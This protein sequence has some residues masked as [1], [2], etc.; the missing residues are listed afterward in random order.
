[1]VAM[2]FFWATLSGKAS[3]KE[4]SPRNGCWA[5]EETAAGAEALV[6][7]PKKAQVPTMAVEVAIVATTLGTLQEFTLGGAAASCGA[8]PT[9]KSSTLTPR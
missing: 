2:A 9:S 5:S 1:M 4:A 8:K 7:L 6:R 3:S